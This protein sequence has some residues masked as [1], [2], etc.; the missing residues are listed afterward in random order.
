[1]KAQRI[2]IIKRG[3][4]L[5][6]LLA[7]DLF[8]E[9]FIAPAV[10]GADIMRAAPWVTAC[11]AL[12]R[13]DPA[14]DSPTAAAA[15]RAEWRR[16]LVLLTRDD[17]TRAAVDAVGRLGSAEAAADFV[18]PLL[19]RFA[20]LMAAAPVCSRVAALQTLRARRLD[21]RAVRATDAAYTSRVAPEAAKPKPRS[22]DHRR[23]HDRPSP[24]KNRPPEA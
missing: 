10:D 2:P 8:V 7:L 3:T 17:V 24:K 1:M 18:A 23:R 4:A 20:E 6:W 21:G 12:A 9:P 11:H 15:R 5:D 19:A 16:F 14:P 22:P 13:R